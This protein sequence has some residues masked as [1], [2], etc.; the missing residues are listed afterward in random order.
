LGSANVAIANEGD[1]FR[2]VY[3][4]DPPTDHR[5]AWNANGH[6]HDDTDPEDFW[7][8]E[9]D[10]LLGEASDRDGEGVAHVQLEGAQLADL[11]NVELGWAEVE[12]VEA[13]MEIAAVEEDTGPH[14]DES[15]RPSRSEPPWRGPP[16]EGLRGSLLG[17]RP[18]CHQQVPV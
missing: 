16:P 12:K 7:P 3:T 1:G 4:V 14:V 13:G 6:A 5:W 17:R 11:L 10:P 15:E 2:M 9:P 18:S 8:V